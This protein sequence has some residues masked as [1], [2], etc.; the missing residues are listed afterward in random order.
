[1]NVV[2]TMCR[3]FLKRLAQKTLVR[4]NR[5]RNSPEKG[6][7]TVADLVVSKNS[8]LL[9]ADD[10]DSAVWRAQR[11]RSGVLRCRHDSGP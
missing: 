7:F 4:R 9:K 3:P 2:K 11:G 5:C 10:I 6:R 8:I 1:M